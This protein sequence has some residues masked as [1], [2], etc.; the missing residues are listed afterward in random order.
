MKEIL[1]K[2]IFQDRLYVQ[3]NRGNNESEKL[4]NNNTNKVEKKAK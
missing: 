4:Y 3:I 1:L 2:E